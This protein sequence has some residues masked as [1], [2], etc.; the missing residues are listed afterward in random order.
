MQN[1][2]NSFAFRITSK[3]PTQRVVMIIERL[4]KAE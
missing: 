2:A 1:L 3:N 4:E